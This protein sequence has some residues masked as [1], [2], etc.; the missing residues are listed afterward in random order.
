MKTNQEHEQHVRDGPKK[1]RTEGG[2]SPESPPSPAPPP[3]AT[4]A[5]GAAPPA[6]ASQRARLA[7]RGSYLPPGTA[8]R[9]SHTPNHI[10][11]NNDHETTR[12]DRNN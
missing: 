1:K 9:H 5:A 8:T 7:R 6:P 12:E 11:T 3:P 10:K 4:A 2:S